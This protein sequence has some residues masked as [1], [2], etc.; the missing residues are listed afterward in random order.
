MLK[1]G[2]LSVLRATHEA[3]FWEASDDLQDMERFPQIH[4]VADRNRE[5]DKVQR[6]HANMLL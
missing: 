3:H 4:M 1:K 6:S 2:H 5:K